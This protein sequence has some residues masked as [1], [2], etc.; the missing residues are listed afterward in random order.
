MLLV[1]SE[2]LQVARFILIYS[3]WNQFDSCIS[4]VRA[5]QAVCAAS[6]ELGSHC[7]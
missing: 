7:L 1:Q 2:E 3:L 6:P 5:L 4:D